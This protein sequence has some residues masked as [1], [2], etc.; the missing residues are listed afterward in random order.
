LS[1]FKLNPYEVLELDWMPSAAVTESDIR[2]SP[3]PTSVCALELTPC[4][5]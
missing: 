1:A 3:H 5:A 2:E 4:G